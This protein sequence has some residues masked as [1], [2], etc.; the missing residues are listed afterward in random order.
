MKSAVSYLAASL[1]VVLSWSHALADEIGYVT[2]QN[3]YQAELVTRIVNHA[4]SRDGNRFLISVTDAE[5]DLLQ[6]SGV[7]FETL[8]KDADPEATYVVSCL[9]HPDYVPPEIDRLA[10]G[11]DIGAGQRLVPMDRAAASSLPTGSGLVATA[12]VELQIP[13]RYL[14]PAVAGLL[15]QLAEYPSDSLANRVSQDSVYAFNT[16]L[17]DFSTRYIWSDS[18]DRARDWIVQKFLGWGYAQVST[19][20]FWFDG[21]WHYNVMAVKPGYAE[22]DHVI[23][24]GGHYDSITYGVEPGPMVFAPGAD[25]DG[26]GV[27]TVMEVA[28]VL[29]D[30]PLRKTII[31]MA[32][33][34]EE[35]GLVGSWD[36]AWGFAS[37]GTNLEVMYNYDMVGYTEN[38]LWDISITSGANSAYR[39]L[40]AATATRVTQLIPVIGSSPGSSDHWPFLQFGYNIVNHIEADFNW[41]GWHTNLDISDRMDFPYLTEVVKMAVASIAI[42]ADA[43]HPTEIE[44]VIDVGD[45]QSLEVAWTNCD[46]SYAYILVWGVASGVY[47]DTVLVPSGQCSYVVAGLTEGQTYYFSVFGDPPAGYP[48]IYSVEGSGIPYVVPRAPKNLTAAPAPNSIELGWEDN[49]EADF[50]HYLVYRRYGQAGY[51][52]Y[53]GGVTSSSLVDTGVLG[54]VNYGYKVTA[55][56]LDGYESDFSNEAETYAATFDGGI[57]IVDEMTAGVG[58]PSQTVQEEYFTQIFENTP[59]SVYQIDSESEALTRS[60]ACRYSSIFWFDDDLIIKA[61][62][63]SEDTLKWYA[64]F[65]EN[66]LLTG[67]RT[68]VFCA[69]PDLSPGDLLYD[70]FGLAQY[71]ENQA[72]DFAGAVGQNGWPSLQVDPSGF[73]GSRLPNICKLVER[74]GA[75]VIAT[76]DSFSDDPAYE[77]QPCGLMYQ[78]ANGLRVLLAFPLYFMTDSSAQGFVSHT[79]AL[80]NETDTLM[81]NG[82]VDGSGSVNVADVV[83]L[84]DYLFCGGIAPS[85]PNAADADA[86]CAVNVADIT[87]LVAYLFFTGPDPLPGCVEP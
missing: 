10:Q 13:V 11:I 25:D 58:M 49:R 73:F 29:A 46:S 69:P 9:C 19:P 8:L 57:L 33:S 1:I 35:V 84:V 71:T 39:D 62:N 37:T 54:Q 44:E 80:F 63:S 79:K 72:T 68:I 53:L 2:I 20:E 64:G 38:T 75:T 31:F 78:T 55:I 47:T 85:S 59:Y 23:V 17:E 70:E 14:P 41:A 3:E 66:M 67:L 87:Y 15:A 61:I 60:Q 86:S 40:T 81:A 56:D 30:I 45:G 12:L 83:Y 22:P 42:V 34:A 51:V 7:E 32:F 50:S 24:I 48:A 27:A 82:D 16:R 76:W 18:I 43:A 28:R 36:A 74:P 6:G 5:R 65:P 52:P 26:S 77:G 4:H 21:D